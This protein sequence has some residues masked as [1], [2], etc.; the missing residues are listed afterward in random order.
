MNQAKANMA[1]GTLP[2]QSAGRV[3]L[4]AVDGSACSDRAVRHAVAVARATPGATLHLLN[5]QPAVDGVVSMFVPRASIK[6]FHREEGD[7]AL[8]SADR[9]CAEAGVPYEKHIGVG[10]PGEI[11]GRFAR[12]LGAGS[13]ISGTRGHGGVAG[14]LLGSVAQDILSHVDVPITFVK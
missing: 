4:V 3:I 8:Q 9:I 13:L 12:E 6:S 7:K 2:A 14:V 10:H 5:V 1:A 11:I